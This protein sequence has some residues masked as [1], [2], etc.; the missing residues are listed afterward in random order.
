MQA[1]IGALISLEIFFSC[2][3]QASNIY[4]FI[5]KVQ[6]LRAASSD[7]FTTWSQP[8]FQ[9]LKCQVFSHSI[10]P[11]PEPL[12]APLRSKRI[13]HF[14][15]NLCSCLFIPVFGILLKLTQLLFEILLLPLSTAQLCIFT[16]LVKTSH[17]FCLGLPSILSIQGT[18]FGAR[19]TGFK[20]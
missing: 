4:G 10:L 17:S 13:L 1:L 18:G 12:Q 16:V 9:L 2:D 14:L 20:Q 8:L 19:W 15:L 6:T 11:H 3:F 5:G 7:A